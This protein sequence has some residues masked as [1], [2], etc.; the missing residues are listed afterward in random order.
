VTYLG[1]DPDHGES[2]N[3]HLWLD[4][5]NAEAYVERIADALVAVDPDG[6]AGYLERAASYRAQLG[7]LDTEIRDR[8]AALPEASRVVISFH[9]AF[10]YFARAYG[11]QIDGLIVESPGQEPSAA[12]VEA[13]VR[14]IR[15]G[16]VRAI[17]A[18]AQF[19]DDLARAIA[20]ET[21]AVV[22]SDLYT[23]TLGDAPLDTYVAIM[24]SNTDRIVEA[25]SGR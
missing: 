11:L 6:A 14:A 21:D 17:L 8:M 23:D 24:R 20:S 4:V 12:Q 15:E 9:D 18:E 22:I 1:G 19:N 5:A 25:L 10:P 13:L 2:V 7:S 16:G 3:P